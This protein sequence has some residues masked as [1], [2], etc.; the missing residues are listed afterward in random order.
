M[1][2]IGLGAGLVARGALAS[3][4]RKLQVGSKACINPVQHVAFG[5]GGAGLHQE[6]QHA[7]GAPAAPAPR[8]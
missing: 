6:D 1:G 2:Q 4:A 8:R 3:L 5:H 7:H